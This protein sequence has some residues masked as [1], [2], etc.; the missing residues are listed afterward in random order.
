MLYTTEERWKVFGAAVAVD[1]G[2]R[3]I[4]SP[5]FAAALAVAILVCQLPCLSTSCLRRCPHRVHVV[6]PVVA[7]HFFVVSSLCVPV[8][9]P[10]CPRCCLRRCP[11]HF[12][13]L[14]R[15]VLVVSPS[16]SWSCPRC[17][18]V[19]FL[20]VNVPVAFLVM[21]SSPSSPC[22][23][24]AILAVIAVS[25]SRLRRCSNADYVSDE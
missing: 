5:A 22:P 3:Y 19:A 4:H 1:L 11:R 14:P 23:H 6:A 8:V 20:V 10:S 2:D 13:S 17:V 24:R 25:S 9:S 16:L 21:S 15:R 18:P 12:P 7:R